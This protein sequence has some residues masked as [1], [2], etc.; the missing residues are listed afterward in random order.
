MTCPKVQVLAELAA[1]LSAPSAKAANAVPLLLSREDDDDCDF[2]SFP[3]LS[4]EETTGN[5]HIGIFSSKGD[6]ESHVESLLSRPILLG[7]Q[8]EEPEVSDSL[9][10]FFVEHLH[11][12]PQFMLNNFGK[13]FATLMNSRLRAYATFL[14]RHAVSLAQ[15]SDVEGVIGIEHKLETMLGIGSQVATNTTDQASLQFEVDSARAETTSEEDS[16]QVVVSV[17][18]K[19]IICVHI[20]LPHVKEDDGDELMKVSFQTNGKIC[21]VFSGN[22]LRVAEV[23]LNMHELLTAMA[24]QASK[25]ISCIVDMTNSAFAVPLPSTPPME[26]NQEQVTHN[27]PKK[28]SRDDDDEDTIVSLSAENCANLVDCLIGELDDT[29]LSPPCAKKLKVLE[30]LPPAA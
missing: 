22:D 3:S 25:V 21:G 9:D 4:L 30:K 24:G 5:H 1:E 6:V 15:C 14:A 23:S 7:Q 12:I 29:V 13:S 19:A 11:A 10:E 28:H 17:P 26:D 8:P 16:A 2:S 27:I 18:L 20:A